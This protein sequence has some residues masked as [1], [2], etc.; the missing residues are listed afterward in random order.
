MS[1]DASA[2]GDQMTLEQA[3]P[4]LELGGSMSAHKS[5]SVDDSLPG[6]ATAACFTHLSWG[7]TEDALEEPVYPQEEGWGAIPW[8]MQRGTSAGACALGWLPKGW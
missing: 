6:A 7:G 2:A 8:E 4:P 5:V 3:I 1:N